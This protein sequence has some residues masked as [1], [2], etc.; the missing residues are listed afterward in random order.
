MVSYSRPM[1]TTALPAVGDVVGVPF[2]GRIERAVIVEDR[3]DFRGHRIVRIRV[4]ERD[5]VEA[6]ELEVP[7]DNLVSI[8]WLVDGGP[9]EISEPGRDGRVFRFRLSGV[10]EPLARRV[11][12]LVTGTYEALTRNERTDVQD[13]ARTAGRAAIDARLGWLE[14]PL[15]L[16]VSSAGI[17]VELP[18]ALRAALKEELRDLERNGWEIHVR[19]DYPPG[20]SIG[21]SSPGL[22]WALLARP[23][24]RYE[25]SG[26]ED[27]DGAA[28]AALASL[29]SPSG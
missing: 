23:G 8:R 29:R 18:G 16:N 22:F 26:C 19:K 21:G 6:P 15:R 4:G 7:T 20:L 3:G 28:E 12:I 25:A 9:E 13:A 5:D 27:A 24:V 14:P 2:A 10:E 1:A 11:T 17:A